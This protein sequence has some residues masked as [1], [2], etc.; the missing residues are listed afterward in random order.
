MGTIIKSTK[1]FYQTKSMIQKV[2]I[3]V[4]VFFLVLGLGGIIMPAM[5]GMHLSSTHNLIH[6][7]TAGVGLWA[8]FSDTSRSAYLFSL[9][10]G[11]FYAFM[12]VIGFIFG[13]VGY[14]GV[15]DA[16]I[17]QNLLRLIPNVLELGS[18]D[19]GMHLLFACV[20]LISAFA[21]QRSSEGETK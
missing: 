20:L 11:F 5:M 15:G 18:V 17:D 4:G 6:L 1:P 13:T 21:W 7:I 10:F 12:G 2:S 16:A 19:H 8:G 9:G 3:G 14:P